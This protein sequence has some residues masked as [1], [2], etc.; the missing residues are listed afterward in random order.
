[1]TMKEFINLQHHVDAQ[2]YITDI[3]RDAISKN[4]TYLTTINIIESIPNDQFI[5]IEHR[6]GKKIRGS[7]LGIEDRKIL[8]QTPISVE[9]IPIWDMACLLYTSPSPRD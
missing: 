6:S 7:V 5:V 4:L 1:M 9:T 3:D 2:P 8:L